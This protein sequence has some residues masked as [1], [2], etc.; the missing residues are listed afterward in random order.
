MNKAQAI[1]YIYPELTDEDY[2][3]QDDWKWPYIKWYNK[4]LPEPTISELETAWIEVDKLQK[5]EVILKD[6]NK[7]LEDY[8][9]AYP[10]QEIKQFSNKLRFAEK[11]IDWGK[12]KY[13]EK[14]AIAKWVTEL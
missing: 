6:F 4:T 7:K 5:K 9:S 11:V 2:I 10:E 13:I 14:L 3:V 8:N 1:K 12:S